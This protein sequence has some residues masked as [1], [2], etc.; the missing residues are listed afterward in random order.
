MLRQ[1]V[2]PRRAAVA[3][4]VAASLSGA[5]ACSRGEAPTDAALQPTAAPPGE[6]SAAGERPAT[7]T[8]TASAA[9]PS[10]RSGAGAPAP[11]SD[12]AG[13]LAGALAH[14]PEG[15]AGNDD[16]EVGE[17]P[18]GADAPPLP[19]FDMRAAVFSG[20]LAGVERRGQVGSI[21][22]VT[23]T[24]GDELLAVAVELRP[25]S[26]VWARTW[27]LPRATLPP[28]AAPVPFVEEARLA[29]VFDPASP[30]RFV[31]VGDGGVI[32]K[33]TDNM[34]E[35]GAIGSFVL[36]RVAA[37]GHLD[38]A[39]SPLVTD[40]WAMRRAWTATRLGDEVLLCFLGAPRAADGSAA[41]PDSLQ[42]GAVSPQTLQWTLAP[43]TI[44]ASQDAASGLAA[45]WLDGGHDQ[46][47]LLLAYDAAPTVQRVFGWVVTRGADGLVASRAVDLTGQPL[48]EGAEFTF[49]SAPHT[50]SA[51]AGIAVVLPGSDV[52]PARAAFVTLDGAMREG[53]R[54]VP[55]PSSGGE[56]AIFTD[57]AGAGASGTSAPLLIYAASGRRGERSVVTFEGAPAAV[58][59]RS[60]FGG[61]AGL[62]VRIGGASGALTAVAYEDEGTGATR[63]AIVPGPAW[64]G[65]AE[66]AQP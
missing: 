55:E 66:A 14:P 26:G 22:S 12:T 20:S 56:S 34:V 60:A 5:A 11:G 19:P 13:A 48:G 10:D 50:F 57:I 7:G 37:D 38:E 54:G 27:R 21:V 51:D 4:A 39:G 43:R 9:A 15:N 16:G 30:P 47:T 64:V 23:P 25:R 46:H 32:V 8:A 65:A 61:G 24:A 42:C 1:L 6:G 53:L 58:D 41:G 35:D 44:A 63:V 59:I 52:A 36:R 31:A 17:K 33:A 49:R 45:P 2:P 18:P 62:G 3:L 28:D 40:P 29:T